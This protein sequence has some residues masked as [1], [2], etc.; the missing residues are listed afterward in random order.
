MG[1]ISAPGPLH[2]F[3]LTEPLTYS[4]DWLAPSSRPG[5]EV[6]AVDPS[7]FEKNVEAQYVSEDADGRGFRVEFANERT[8]WT[9]SDDVGF[10]SWYRVESSSKMGQ[11]SKQRSLRCRAK[12]VCSYEKCRISY[13]GK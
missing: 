8:E 3:P 6:E 12:P 9:A 13:D 5:G 2:V 10:P 11:R 4:P 7:S 1:R